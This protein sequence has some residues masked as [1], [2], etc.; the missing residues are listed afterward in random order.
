[1]NNDFRTPP[2][3]ILYIG[4]GFLALAIALTFGG[5]GS[6]STTPV[7]NYAHAKRIDF[8]EVVDKVRTEPTSIEKLVYVK[9]VRQFPDK[10]IVDYSGGKSDVVADI[11]GE[12]DYNVL[13][14]EAERN[15]VTRESLPMSG[16]DA[17]REYVVGPSEKGTDPHSNL[18]STILTVL[19]IVTP[20]AI[21]GFMFYQFRQMKGGGG[22]AGAFAKSK[23]K[24]FDPEKGPLV[25]FTDVAGLDE[26]KEAMERI[27]DYLKDP[28]EI[29]DLGG[30]IAKCV[31]LVGPPGTGKTL[32]AKAVAGEAGVHAFYI[33]AAEFVEMFVGVGASRVRDMFEQIRAKLP[34]ILLIDELDAVAQHRGAGVGGG[35]DERHQTLDQLLSELDGFEDN[36][37][38][39]VFGMTNRDNML[40]PAVV[41]SGRFGDKKMIV[42]LPD[43]KGRRQIIEVH[44]KD[45][46]L[47]PSIDKDELAGA[48]SGLSG[49]D[50]ASLLKVHAPDA[51]I[52]RCR[53]QFGKGKKATMITREDLDKGISAIQMGGQ[54]NEG[55]SKRLSMDV[56]NLLSYHELGHALVGEY[57]FRMNKGWADQWG[58]QVRKITIIGAGG[59]GGYTLMQ[60]DEDPFCMTKEG[61]LGQITSLLAANRAEQMFLGTT[62]T[63]AS[64]DIDRAYTLAKN[65]VTLWGM[66][67]LGWICVGKQ[68]SDPY[69]GK[70]MAMSG[71]YGLGPVSSNQI[72]HEIFLI[73]ADCA[74]RAERILTELKGLMTTI[75]PVLI[76][77]ETM[78]RERFCEIWDQH[79]GKSGTPRVSMDVLPE[80]ELVKHLPSLGLLVPTSN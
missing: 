24:T 20:I 76:D 19:M 10:V 9:G 51:A 17:Q 73:Q 60:G 66:S 15:K 16:E 68:S 31:L 7:A 59:A 30:K 78:L 80:E 8:S 52:A 70:S 26:T 47:D 3:W 33:N 75:A 32:L 49:A 53:K 55:K 54:A 14:S 61:L 71:G 64:N 22:A 67:R 12:F 42:D 45:V 46:K 23:H 5:G 27:V 29:K 72:D 39:I 77:E 38:L 65:M 18:I 74:L 6:T 25:K 21:L 79:F 57:L 63:G 50:I 58:D 11:P 41:R 62:S 56:K 37:G 40:D 34:A 13:A 35:N 69:L 36:S 1:M 4:I 43:K 48:T 44:S 28:S 2:K